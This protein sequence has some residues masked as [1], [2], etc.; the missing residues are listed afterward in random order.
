MAS[1][2]QASSL[3]AHH[4]RNAALACAVVLAVAL[5][6]GRFAF[7]PLLPLMLKSGALDI[8]HGGWLASA[9]YAGYLVGALSC[10]AIRIDHARMVRLALASSARGPSCSRRNGACGSSPNSTRTVSPA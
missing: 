6:V 9:N 1:T 10:A 5:G 4:A 8:R 3:P 7:T 2:A